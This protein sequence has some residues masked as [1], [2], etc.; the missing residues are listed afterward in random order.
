MLGRGEGPRAQ[1]HC[2]EGPQQL[3]MLWSHIP[4]IVAIVSYASNRPQT[5]IGNYAGPYM[6]AR[7]LQLS[8]AGCP[9]PA[10]GLLGTIERG[11]LHT[12]LV[13]VLMLASVTVVLLTLL[14]GDT[15]HSECRRTSVPAR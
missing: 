8:R 12:L 9:R 15:R 2:L 10:S 5:E 6:S 4:C 13:L 11:S 14:A 3:P 1:S 7:I